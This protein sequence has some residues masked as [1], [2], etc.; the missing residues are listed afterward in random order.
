MAL[1]RLGEQGHKGINSAIAEIRNRFVIMVGADGA[2]V[3]DGDE[4]ERMVAGGA[5]K[6]NVVS[7]PRA[8]RGCC[9][10]QAKAE[11]PREPPPAGQQGRWMNLDDYLDGT[12]V[13]PEPTIGGDRDD[14]IKFLYSGRW[15]T[16]IG[17]TTAGKTW[18]AL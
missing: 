17:L 3:T 9:G 8:N 4:V 15:H 18:W 2:D 13:A 7:T 12:Y 10:T 5:V 1:M 6:I 16:V 11:A 14:Y